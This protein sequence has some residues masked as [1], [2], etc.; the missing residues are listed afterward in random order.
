MRLAQAV[1]QLVLDTFVGIGRDEQ[2]VAAVRPRPAAGVDGVGVDRPRAPGDAGRPAPAARSASVSRLPRRRPPAARPG[3]N[4]G[5][6]AHGSSTRGLRAPR[7]CT[8]TGRRVLSARGDAPF[9][10]GA[11][12]LRRRCRSQRRRDLAGGV[13]DRHVAADS[14]SCALISRGISD[15]EDGEDGRHD[16]QADQEPLVRDRRHELAAGDERNL[17]A[18]S[19]ECSSHRAGLQ[20]GAE[21]GSGLVS[22]PPPATMR[23]NTSS[24]RSRASSTRA[25]GTSAASRASARPGRCRRPA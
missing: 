19:C 8:A 13:D 3:V 7:R 4:A 1:A 16:Q 15:D 12:R 18:L 5:G 10:P 17:L 14:A 6:R 23:T 21:R 2:V 24:S 9:A 25:G 20:A 22:P 11:D